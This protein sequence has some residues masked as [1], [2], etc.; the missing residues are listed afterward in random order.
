MTRPI[1]KYIPIK[2][3]GELVSK[4]VTICPMIV[5][6]LMLLKKKNNNLIK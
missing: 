2:L 6:R 3:S 5:T 4:C 1:D